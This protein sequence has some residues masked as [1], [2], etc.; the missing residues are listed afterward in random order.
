MERVL[1]RDKDI[2]ILTIETSCDETSV[3]IIQNSLKI[4]TEVLSQ[5][6]YVL[7]MVG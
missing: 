1:N 3:S 5:M 7:Y 6:M 2:Y 4:A